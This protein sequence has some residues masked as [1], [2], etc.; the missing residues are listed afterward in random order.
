MVTPRYY[1]AKGGTEIM[2]RNFAISLNKKGIR[3]DIMTFNMTEKWN[4]K[5]QGNVEEIDG[6]TVYKIP[7]LNWLPIE[8][9]F[10]NT[11]GINLIPGRFAHI[12]S[13]YNILHFHELELSFPTFSM[14]IRKPK[15]L[16]LHGL[17]FDT[18]ARNIIGRWL[19]KN[20]ANIYVAITRQMI[21][22]LIRL[23]ITSSKIKYVPNGV[24]TKLFRPDKNKQS[25]LVIFVG[26]VSYG[27]GVHILLEALDYIKTPICLAVVGPI[28]HNSIKILEMIK[29]KNSKGRHKVMYL[30][31]LDQPDI[32]KWYQKASI[33]VLPSF[34]EAF[35]IVI[36][37]ALACETAVIA[38]SIGG[39]HEI[40][41]NGETGILVKSSNS[42]QIANAIQYLL[43]NDDARRKMAS[44]G[45]EQ[46]VNQYS[47]EVATKKLCDI[48]SQLLS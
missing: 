34:W 11:Q 35:P 14:S 10:R 45:R 1:P 41:K 4:A 18:L 25:N 21:R 9:S 13:K 44:K 5:W 17:D 43:N 27:K 7:G 47:L 29:E 36:L 20:S 3:T 42:F 2:V 24:D 30:G 15:I 48:Y 22:D 37:E 12:I 46:V 16:H 28:E 39:I 23:G 40:I 19:F 8:H 26:R 38:T 32:I 6:I 33:L 31:P